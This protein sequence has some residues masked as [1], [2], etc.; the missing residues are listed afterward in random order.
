MGRKKKTECLMN[1]VITNFKGPAK[2][3]VITGVRYNQEVKIYFFEKTH[4]G[5]RQI[6]IILNFT[7]WCSDKIESIFLQFPFQVELIENLIKI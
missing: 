1:S 7:Q 3:F 4:I 2:L 6:K 5:L